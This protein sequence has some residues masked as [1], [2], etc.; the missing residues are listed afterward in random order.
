MFELATRE[1]AEGKQRLLICDRHDSH[2]SGNF[3]AHCMKYKITLLVL[4]AHSSHYTQLLDVAVFDSLAIA[5]SQETDC[6]TSN[7][8]ARISKAE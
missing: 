2:I 5:L 7:S 6:L 1:K 8:I 4:P 3:I